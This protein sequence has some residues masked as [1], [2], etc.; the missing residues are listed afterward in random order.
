MNDCVEIVVI[1][2]ATRWSKVEIELVKN[3]VRVLV[4]SIL[5]DFIWSSSRHPVTLAISEGLIRD[6]GCVATSLLT[7]IALSL[8]LPLALSGSLPDNENEGLHDPSQLSRNPQ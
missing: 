6:A 4:E 8:A 1:S 2:E 3:Y 5:L 7:C